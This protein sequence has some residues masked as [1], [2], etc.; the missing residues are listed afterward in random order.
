M[1]GVFSGNKLGV[2]TKNQAIVGSIPLDSKTHLL[3]KV[4]W[5][6]L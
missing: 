3:D 6:F 5:V 1:F 4:K 2:S